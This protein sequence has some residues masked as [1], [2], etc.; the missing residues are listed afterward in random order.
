MAEQ[1]I[2]DLTP[3]TDSLIKD[4]TSKSFVSDVLEASVKAPVIVDFWAPWCG[5]CRVI[6]PALT[7]IAGDFKG[8]VAVLKINVDQNQT[9][10]GQHGVMSIPTLLY[11]KDGEVTDRSMGSESPDSLRARADGLLA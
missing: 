6:A 10:A 2:G 11:V 8:Q 3:T 5:P 7:T 9:L 1:I 4:A